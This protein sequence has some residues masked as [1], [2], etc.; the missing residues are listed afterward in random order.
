M[1][2]LVFSVLRYIKENKRPNPIE[3]IYPYNTL[4]V[5]VLKRYPGLLFCHS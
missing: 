1:Y 3:L 5:I 4:N 2:A